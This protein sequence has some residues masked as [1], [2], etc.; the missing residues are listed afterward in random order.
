MFSIQ[1]RCGKTKKN[2][3]KQIGEFFINKCCLEA[4]YDKLGNKAGE[5]VVEREMTDEEAAQDGSDS[6]TTDE[7]LESEEA[8]E[9][10]A[11]A[12]EMTNEEAQ[13]AKDEP[14]YE[15]MTAKALK[16]LCR[17]KDIK[18]SKR[19]TRAKLIERLTK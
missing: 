12:I 6:G 13:A 15:N 5:E 3:K 17:L 10:M 19:D 4:G 11:Q 14:D 9:E 18:Y 8:K 7:V 2:F 16:E 1:C